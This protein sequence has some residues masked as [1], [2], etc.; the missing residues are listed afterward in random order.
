MALVSTKHLLNGK[1][2]ALS[3]PESVSLDGIDSGGHVY[4]CIFLLY[5]VYVYDT[6]RQR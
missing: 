5:A 6:N 3:Q 2:E 4:V 1:S